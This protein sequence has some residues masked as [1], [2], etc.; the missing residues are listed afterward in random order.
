[1]KVLR[2]AARMIGTFRWSRDSRPYV[3]YLQEV[4]SDP[5]IVALRRR[6]LA[7]LHLQPRDHV[8]DLGCGPGTT[9]AAIAERLGPDGAIH[10]VDLN[11]EMISAA[12]RVAAPRQLGPRVRYQMDDIT[13]LS[14]EDKQFDACYCERVFQ[15]LPFDGPARAAKEILRILKPGGRFVVLDTDWLNTEIHIV[16]AVLGRLIID[17]W[18]RHL[19]NPGAGQRLAAWISSAGSIKVQIESTD[20]RLLLGSP[21]TTLLTGAAQGALKGPE[22]AQWTASL[23]EAERKQLTFGSVRVVM[24]SGVTP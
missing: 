6:A 19:P 5:A 14:F 8:V 9:V 17:A 18:A 7:K 4:A 11:P 21:T 3:Q 2:A 22:L 23:A 12:R 24:V 1:M 10:G 16:G 13:K 20:M 15:H